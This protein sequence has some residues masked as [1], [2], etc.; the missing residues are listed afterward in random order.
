[1]NILLTGASGF[2]GQKII[3]KLLLKKNLKLKVTLPRKTDPPLKL[4][5]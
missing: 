2:L 1:M 4:V 5:L 3:Q